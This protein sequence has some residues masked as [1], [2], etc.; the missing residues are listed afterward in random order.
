MEIQ[1][2]VPYDHDLGEKVI[3][4]KCSNVIY[5]NISFDKNTAL[6]KKKFVITPVQKTKNAALFESHRNTSVD[7]IFVSVTALLKIRTK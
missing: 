3:Y 1:L 4:F 6:L 7:F 5:G 2:H